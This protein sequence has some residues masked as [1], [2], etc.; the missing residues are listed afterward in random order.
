MK[1]E[2]YI[3]VTNLSISFVLPLLIARGASYRAAS[4]A[5]EIGGADAMTTK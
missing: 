4:A 3:D 2:T 5:P 1:I